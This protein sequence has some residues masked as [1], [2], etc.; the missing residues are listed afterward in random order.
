MKKIFYGD[1]DETPLEEIIAI[2]PKL[3]GLLSETVTDFI[4]QI[5]DET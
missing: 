3:T 1:P 2:D 5:T 4:N